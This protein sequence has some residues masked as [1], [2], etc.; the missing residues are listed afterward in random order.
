MYMNNLRRAAVAVCAAGVLS[1]IAVSPASA[2]GKAQVYTNQSEAGRVNYWS[3]TDDFRVSDTKC[4]GR[5][6]YAQYQ[7]AR[8]ADANPASQ[9]RLPHLQG[10]QPQLHQWADHQVP[11][12]R[13]HSRPT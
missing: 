4:D 13:Q 9:R 1:A 3:S 5:S 12:L 8:G 10:L 7:R 6:V 2:T 11:G